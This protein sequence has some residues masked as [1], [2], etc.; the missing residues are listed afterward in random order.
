MLREVNVRP[1][2]PGI[3]EGYGVHR[4]EAGLLDWSYV[5]ERMEASRNYW[6]STTRPDGRPHAAPVWGVW[7]EGVF[8]FGTDR[9][10]RKA[11]NLRANPEM[12][13]HLESGDDCVIFEGLAEEIADASLRRAVGRA[14]AAKYGLD[15]VGEAGDDAPPLYALRPRVA[16]A[17]KESD[18]PVTATRWR[19]GRGS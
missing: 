17:W 4:D 19:F 18:F 14:Y 5:D 9:D 16:L 13:V 1:E 11:R 15:G 6:I 10:S 8:Y 12:V 2:R 7:F 3:V